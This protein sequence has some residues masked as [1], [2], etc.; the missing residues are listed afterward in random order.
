VRSGVIQGSTIGPLLFI[1]FINELADLLGPMFVTSKL[2]AD[3]LKVYA[4]VL[5]TVDRDCFQLALDRI[6]AWCSD[7][8]LQIAIKKCCLLCIGSIPTGIDLYIKG[9][10]LPEVST[11][12]DL[13]IT[14]DSHLSFT[15][16]FSSITCTANQR[17]NLL[18]RS[19]LTRNR[20]VLVKAY[21]TYVRPFLEYNLV[22]WSPYKIVLIR[23]DVSV[24][25]GAFLSL[26][27]IL[28]FL[29]VLLM[30][31]TSVLK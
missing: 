31:S 1:S 8:Q 15:S 27:G 10:Q 26:A 25:S 6:A 5:T 4:E 29:F 11:V 21:V 9:S 18:F 3:D 28:L 12:K 7:W 2:F 19:F 16:H 14:F 20:S 13:G 23:V 17:V 24:P 22:V 30:L